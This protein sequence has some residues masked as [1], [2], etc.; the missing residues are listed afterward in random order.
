MLGVRLGIT[1]MIYEETNS[2]Y[3]VYFEDVEAVMALINL[4]ICTMHGSIA[5]YVQGYEQG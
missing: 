3:Q 4:S 2:P 1:R 5:P